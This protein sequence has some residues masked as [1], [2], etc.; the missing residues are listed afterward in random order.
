MIVTSELVLQNVDCDIVSPEALFAVPARVAK[1]FFWL[2][3]AFGR[4]VFR[5]HGAIGGSGD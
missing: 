2:F 4:A 1:R 3:W 5:L